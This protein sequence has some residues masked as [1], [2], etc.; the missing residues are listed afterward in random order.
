MVFQQFNSFPSEETEILKLWDINNVENK[1]EKLRNLNGKFSFTDG[2]PSTSSLKGLHMGHLLQSYIKDAMVK[3]KSLNG[4]NITKTIGYD[5]GGIPVSTKVIE[6]LNLKNE[7]EI[8]NYDMRKFNDECLK[9]S[10]NCIDVYQKQLK[11]IGRWTGNNQY[12]TMDTS[13]ME[14]VWWSF[15]TMHEKGLVY[16]GNKVMAWSTGCKCTLSKTESIQN[17]IKVNDPSVYVKFPLTNSEYQII[18]W[19]STPWSLPCNLAVAVNPN[20]TYCKV[21]LTKDN[22]K[23]IVCKDL[24]KNVFGKKMEYEIKEEFKG[25]ILEGLRYK[26]PFNYCEGENYFKVILADYVDNKSGTGCVHIAPAYGQDDMNVSINN[27]IIRKNDKAPDFINGDGLFT[28]TMWKGLYFKDA[29]VEIIKYLKKENLMFSHTK[30]LHDYPHCYR[31]NTPL[32]YKAQTSLFVNVEVLK[33]RIL[34]NNINTNFGSEVLKKR[35][36]NYIRNSI[37]WSIS[38]DKRWGTPIPLW[39]YKDE[40]IVIGSIAELEKLSGIKVNSLYRQDVDNITIPSKKYKGEVL[41]RVP[42]VLDV[43]WESAAAPFAQF[44]YPFTEESVAKFEKSFPATFITEATEQIQLWFYNMTILATALF[45]KPAFE[46]VIC[47]GMVLAEDGKKFSKRLG[48]YPDIFEVIGEHGSDALRVFFLNSTLCKGQSTNYSNDQIKQIVKGYFLPFVNSAKFLIE[49]HHICNNAGIELDWSIKTDNH[50]DK[51]ILSLLKTIIGKSTAEMDSYRIYDALPILLDFIDKLCN[52]YIR[53]NRDRFKGFKGE[54]DR[55]ESIIT[56]TKAITCFSI[57]MTPF[58]PFL[59][60]SIYQRIKQFIPDGKLSIHYYLLED[61]WKLLQNDV[62]DCQMELEFKTMMDIII[63]FR[64]LRASKNLS[65]KY[66][67]KKALI[68]CELKDELCHYVLTEANIL[69]MEFVKIDD[70]VEVKIEPKMKNIGKKFR[71]DAKKVVSLLGDI[72]CKEVLDKDNFLIGGFEI[73]KDDIGIGKNVVNIPL[74]YDYD[75][76]DSILVM[77][78]LEQDEECLAVYYARCITTSIQQLRKKAGLHIWDKIRTCYNE[79]TDEFLKGIIEKYNDDIKYTTKY[80]LEENDGIGN[81][82]IKE[83]IVIDGKILSL[84]IYKAE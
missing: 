82:I 30:F 81:S 38:R 15:K 63:Q 46:N 39:K 47:S 3:W 22:S 74:D 25:A 79:K 14:S 67:I 29:D 41:T 28:D 4:F 26:P 34:Q 64:T 44:H 31:T 21:N 17:Y 16:E 42:Y 72:N 11:R 23:Y 40:E 35:F 69:N 5:Q 19:T 7:E 49:S 84:V 27:G 12:K 65:L 6:L 53:L 75:L 78:N 60:E 80:Y 51:W 13:Y 54:K 58:I 62:I 73:S 43:W 55:M 2:P 77:A 45:D 66:P 61:V 36:D 37:D 24:L 1:S 33:E 71:K 56:L 83:D 50:F 9:Y 59:S 20:L 76:D 32:I 57:A 70:Y 48:N 10:N 8:N 52:W 18:I 68:S